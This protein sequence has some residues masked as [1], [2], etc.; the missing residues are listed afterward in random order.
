MRTHRVRLRP[1]SPA[2]DTIR[3]TFWPFSLISGT[4]FLQTLTCEVRSVICGRAGSR[5]IV[6]VL[7]ACPLVCLVLQPSVLL[8][9]LIG[10]VLLLPSIPDIGA[11][12]V[13]KG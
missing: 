11:A 12:Y 5:H 1:E 10:R 7:T 9:V 13:D 4:L 8:L 3:A 6:A 2:R